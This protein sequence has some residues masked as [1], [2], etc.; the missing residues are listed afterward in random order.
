MIISKKTND[1]KSPYIE[2]GML[3]RSGKE[4]WISLELESG[5]YIAYV[6]RDLLS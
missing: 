6:F 5:D 1:P 4:M 2:Q 3:K